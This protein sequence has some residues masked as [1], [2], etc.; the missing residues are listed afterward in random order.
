MKLKVDGMSCGHCV[1]AISDAIGELDA[2]ARVDLAGGTVEIEGV[3][4]RE[5][6][7]RAIEAEGYSVT[8]MIE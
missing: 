1:R 3:V 2:S 7:I 4:D 6:A 8:G 5:A